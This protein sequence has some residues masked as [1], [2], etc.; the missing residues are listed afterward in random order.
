MV[1][2]HV[3]ILKPVRGVLELATTP[4]QFSFYRAGQSVKD[5]VAFITKARDQ[6]KE[7]RSL[8]DELNKVYEENVRLKTV[9][10]ENKALR[11]QINALEPTKYK[12]LAANTLGISRYLALDKGSIDG[13]TVGFPV[14]SKDILVGKVISVSPRTSQVQLITDPDSRIPVEVITDSKRAKG[15]LFGQFQSGLLLDQVLQEEKISQNDRVVTSG[16]NLEY[17]KGLLIGKIDSITKKDAEFFQ[18]AKIQPLLDYKSLDTVFIV[19]Q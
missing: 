8:K 1:F 15:V 3:G 4:I 9:A 19:I 6:E 12:L 10:D 11:E 13:V 5:N 18:K 2:D 16:E 7:I 17:P 14:V